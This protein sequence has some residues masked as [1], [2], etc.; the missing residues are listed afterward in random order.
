MRRGI[1]KR[2]RKAPHGMRTASVLSAQRDEE[3]REAGG[4]R[5]LP[6]SFRI[7]GLGLICFI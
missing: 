3:A 7:H 4:L 5:R 6:A 2:K 1:N